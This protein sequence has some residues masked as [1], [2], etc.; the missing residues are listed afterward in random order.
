MISFWA[1][2]PRKQTLLTS[3]L[4]GPDFAAIEQGHPYLPPFWFVLMILPA[5]I[6]GDSIRLLQSEL[7]T[8]AKG[9]RFSKRE[10]GCINVILIAG[11]NLVYLVTVCSVFILFEAVTSGW[12]NFIKHGGLTSY[13]DSGVMIYLILILLAL[14]QQMSSWLNQ[15]F[16]LIIPILILIA[17]DFT[18]AKWNPFNLSLWPRMLSINGSMLNFAIISCIGLA[19]SY[20]YLYGKYELK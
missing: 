17:T 1:K 9:L 5:F 6:I 8:K 14:I 12:Q 10:F 18:I 13:L 2:I 11:T 7:F 4:T 3:I 20:I 15:A 19:T 16:L